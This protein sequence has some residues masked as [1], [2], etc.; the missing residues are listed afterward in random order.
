VIKAL[1]SA[2][3]FNRHI[4][5][6]DQQITIQQYS[7]WYTGHWW[8]GC[9][10]WYSEEG[11][12]WGRSLPRPLLAVPNVTAHPSTASTNHRING[13][14]LCGFNVPIK[15]LEGKAQRGWRGCS[16]WPD[17]DDELAQKIYRKKPIFTWLEVTQ[18]KRYRH[19]QYDI[20]TIITTYC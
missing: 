1:L 9:Y 12:G 2:E 17:L 19:S 11:T 14:L 6:T 20:T 8:V 10:I 4:K 15:G 3:P 16:K 18:L 5:T 7:D 13:P